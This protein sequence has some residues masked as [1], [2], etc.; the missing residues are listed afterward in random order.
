MD[1]RRQ[2]PRVRAFV[3]SWFE[4]DEH[5]AFGPIENISKG[6][7]FLRTAID[8]PIGTAGRFRLLLAPGCDV[9]GS[10]RVAWRREENAV[11][12]GVG[13]TFESIDEGRDALEHFLGERLGPTQS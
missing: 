5:A 6:G 12:S 9:V 4:D 3:F 7:M 1:E 8:A 10:A 13:L 2:L 11:P